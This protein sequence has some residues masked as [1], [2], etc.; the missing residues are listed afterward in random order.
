VGNQLKDGGKG[1]GGGDC[2]FRVAVNLLMCKGGLYS[3]L[4][5]AQYNG[6]ST[7]IFHPLEW[8]VQIRPNQYFSLILSDIHTKSIMRVITRSIHCANKYKK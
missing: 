4:Y 7:E 1:G 6:V 5:T 8:E 3:T 2:G